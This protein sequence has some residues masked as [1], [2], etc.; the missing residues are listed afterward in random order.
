MWKEITSVD[1][2]HNEGIST[3]MKNNPVESLVDMED[4]AFKTFKVRRF[5][6]NNNDGRSMI[7]LECDS[8]LLNNESDIST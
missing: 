7:V 2:V 6:V 3:Y 5:V 4:E 8:I 1:E